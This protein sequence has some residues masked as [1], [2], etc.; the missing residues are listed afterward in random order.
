MFGF[1]PNW[2][3]PAVKTSQAKVNTA[4]DTLLCGKLVPPDPMEDL[5]V[6]LNWL[7]GILPT[8]QSGD[9]KDACH[10]WCVEA[11][12]L[13]DNLKKLPPVGTKLPPYN[14]VRCNH[15][16]EF[17]GLEHLSPDG[18]YTCRGCRK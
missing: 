9:L 1:A 12:A 5:Q 17:I 18:S 7:Y 8:V 14:C 13:L 15:R 10:R 3:P 2:P 11:T 4:W 6:N 16:N